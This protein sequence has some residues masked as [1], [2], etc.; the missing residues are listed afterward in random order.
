MVY[1]LAARDNHFP[2]PELALREPDG[3]LAIGGDLSTDRLLN[4]YRNGIFPWFT[5]DDPPL[6]WSPDPR[7]VF[8][9]QSIHESRSMR[10]FRRR[11]E[12]TVTLNQAFAEVI[13][14]CAQAHADGAGTWIT[15]E[16][17]RAYQRL[18]EEGHAHSIEIWRDGQLV[19]GMYGVA[20][21]GIFCGESMFHRVTN[22]SKLALLTFARHYFQAGGQLID[23]Q[24]PN[25]HLHSLGLKQ[26][27]RAQFLYQLRS[28]AQKSP[29]LAADFWQSRELKKEI[30]W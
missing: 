23:A 13:R 28:F 27:P 25:E 8:T 20:I 6:W 10:R 5:E 9:P 15:E 22:A 16:M 24:V 11:T 29:P 12:L 19:G 17:Q 18:H 30:E 21:P 7:A 1:R 4:A 2:R 3:L 14:G 26:L